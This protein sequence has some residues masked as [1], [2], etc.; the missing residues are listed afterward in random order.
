MKK[1][2][3]IMLV[4]E[5]AEKGNIISMNAINYLY[6]NVFFTQYETG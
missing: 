6:L 5:V 1:S 3:G 2:S 4:A